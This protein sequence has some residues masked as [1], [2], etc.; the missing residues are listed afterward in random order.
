M[1][2]LSRSEIKRQHKQIEQAAREMLELNNQQ[3]IRLKL[4]DE[5]IEAIQLTRSLKGGALKRQTKY[6]AKL[7]KEEPLGDIL[8]Q[9][10]WMKG[11]KLQENKLH[12]QAEFHRDAIINEALEAR[13]QSLREG[14]DFEMDWPSGTIERVVEDLSGIDEKDVR[15]LVYQYVRTRNKVH[16]RELFRT[17]RAAVE[18]RKLDE[19]DATRER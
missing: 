11:S 10:K 1:E 3:L 19:A 9:L 18:R 13:E 6:V 4:G 17:I 16:Y 2:H 7:L 12:H 14:T 8:E 5:L 15:R